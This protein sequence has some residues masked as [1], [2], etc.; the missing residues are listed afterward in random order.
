[1]LGGSQF[2]LPMFNLRFYPVMT[3][4][5][6]CGGGGKESNAEQSRTRCPRVPQNIVSVARV[7]S[8]LDGVILVG[9]CWGSW[10]LC[11]HHHLFW[12][13]SVLIIYHK[14]MCP[15]A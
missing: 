3:L 10:S 8:D 2:Y 13:S 9:I 1:M 11:S 15:E 4:S 7:E 6:H 12:K 14:L 5:W